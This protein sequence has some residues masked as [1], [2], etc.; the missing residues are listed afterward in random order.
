ML[1]GMSMPMGGPMFRSFREDPSVARAKI[2][3]GTMRRIARFARPYRA[4]IAV[5]LTL[6]AVDAAL[7]AITPL[8]YQA[9]IDRGITP[10]RMKLVIALAGVLA[11]LALASAALG[12]AERY[13]SARIGEGLIFDLRTKVFS[14]VQELS[15]AFFSRTHTGALTQRLNG[16][17][18]GAQRAFTSTLSSLV[19]NTLTVVFVI[20]AMVSLSWKIT[21]VSLVL[22]PVF[23]APVRWVG[24]KLAAI[25]RRA[26]ELNATISQTMTERFSVAGATLVKNYGDP[27]RESAVYAD[28]AAAVRGIGIKSALYSSA[29][30]I[31]MTLVASIAVA[32]VYGL[33]GSLAVRGELTVGVVVALVT[34]LNRLYGPITAL[35]NVQVDV[36]TT[37]VSFERVLEVLDLEPLVQDMPDAADLVWDCPPVPA[38]TA[39]GQSG[40]GRPASGSDQGADQSGDLSD[41]PAVGV[42][43]SASQGRSANGGAA[44]RF[45]PA[46]RFD[47]VWFAYPSGDQVS[48]ASLEGGGAI[49]AE[50]PGWT[51]Q[52]VSFEVPRGSMVALVGPSGAGKS[53]A[54]LL[55]SRLYEAN[56]GVVELCGHDV[57][58]LTSRSIHRTIGVVSQDAHLFHTTLRDNLVY[59]RPDVSQGEIWQALERAQAGFV[60]GLPQGLDTVVG[61]RGY[62]LSGGERQRIAIARLLIKAPDVVVLDEATAHLD[63]ESELA[64]QHA[65]AEA[66][67]GRTSL[68]I[69]HRLSTIRQ[70]SQIVVLD[71][72]RVVERGT[73]LEL[74]AADGLYADLYRVQF[75]E[76]AASQPQ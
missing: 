9:I 38:P 37:L 44:H 56:R 35:S 66:L 39:K 22:L 62:R 32:L 25:A 6:I 67:R 23:I 42:R 65:L 75:A 10:G 33:G 14:H 28:E 1:E 30:R 54:S 19:S 73:H 64:V 21:L 45:V 50:Q 76:A 48:L 58:R 47:S 71:Q 24:R 8:I 52:D 29:F 4:A 70:A 43:S 11:G 51:L 27:D 46:I 55:V 34:L 40:G 57:R 36:M 5:F 13:L 41:D 69:A 72:G 74:L 59:A 26:M 63:S 2:S 20:A 61:D 12:L 17:V 31:A 68:V 16:D 53:T 15:L 49:E 7:G 18:L 60:A 3:P